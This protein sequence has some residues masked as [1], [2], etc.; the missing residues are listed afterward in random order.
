VQEKRRRCALILTAITLERNEVEKHLTQTREIINQN[1]PTV[2]R[3]EFE[4]AEVIWDVFVADTGAG[5]PEAAAATAWLGAKYSPELSI[6]V[7]VAGG[8]KDVSIGDVAVGDVVYYYEYAKV[9]EQI[10]C[11]PRLHYPSNLLLERA[12]RESTKRDWRKR[13]RLPGNVEAKVFIKPIAAGEK[14]VAETK[15]EPAQLIQNTYGDAIAVSME[16]FG[17]LEAWKN[18]RNVHAIAI[19]GISDM[20]EKKTAACDELNQP[21]AAAAAS[22]FAFELLSKYSDSTSPTE[23]A[24]L[25]QA[26]DHSVIA[27]SASE[28]DVIQNLIKLAGNA[29]SGLLNWPTTLVDGTWIQQDRYSAL[30]SK[31]M[32]ASPSCTIILG[33]PG[34]GKSALLSKLASALMADSVACLAIKADLLPA[35]I[36]SSTKLMQH[37]GLPIPVEELL[38]QI[39]KTRRVVLIIDQLDALADLSDLRTGRLNVL[40]HLMNEL[41][42][43]EGLHIVAS[44]RNFEAN[45]DTRINRIGGERIILEPPSWSQIEEYLRTKNVASD[46][47][48]EDLKDLLRYPEN[49][50]L[51]FKL[52]TYILTDGNQVTTQQKI[53]DA[54]WKKV[55]EKSDPGV[56]AVSEVAD[57]I[58]KREELWIPRALLDC[59]QTI[60]N[61][62]IED[63]ILILDNSEQLVSFRHQSLFEFTRAKVFLKNEGSL[64]NFVKERQNALFVRPLL[65]TTLHY[66]RGNDVLRFQQEF[67]ALWKDMS[68]RFHI[69]SLLIEF[70]GSQ[71]M[72]TEQEKAWLM[73][74]LLDPTLRSSVLTAVA[75]SIGWFETISESA[76]K[77]ILSKPVDECSEVIPLLTAALQFCQNQVLQL[78]KDYWL[79]F[80]ERDQLSFRVLQSLSLWD[81][82]S[83]E[84]AST[85][86]R[87]APL[88][89]M[90]VEYFI[91]KVS[92]SSPQGAVSL[93]LARLQYEFDNLP[94]DVEVGAPSSGDRPLDDFLHTTLQHLENPRRKQLIAILDSQDRFDSVE[95]AKKAPIHFVKLV[96]PWFGNALKE[97][98]YKEHEVVNKFLED[99][100]YISARTRKEKI[101]DYSIFAALSAAIHLFAAQSMEEFLQFVQAMKDTNLV[102]IQR[103]LVRGFVAIAERAP[104]EAIDFLLEDPRRLHIGTTWNE[105]ED[106]QTLIKALVPTSE[107]SDRLR[108]ENAILNYSPYHESIE[109]IEHRP[110][111]I[112]SARIRLLKSLEG[113]T[114]QTARSFIESKDYEVNDFDMTE[115]QVEWIGSPISAD[116]MEQADITALKST[117]DVLD[118]TTGDSHPSDFYLGG[119]IQ[120]SAE[121]RIMAKRQPEKAV[122]LIGQFSPSKNESAAAGA[123]EGLADSAIDRE[124]VFST[125]LECYRKGFRSQ[126]F[127][128]S[129][130]F[131]LGRIANRDT[132]FPPELVNVLHEFLRSGK[133]MTLEQAYAHPYSEEQSILFGY[134][135]RIV[136]NGT[137]PI[138]HA[139]AGGLLFSK[140]QNS[141]LWLQILEGHLD[142]EEN[143]AV[144][145]ELSMQYLVS[146][147]LV[148]RVRGEKFL[149]TLFEKHAALL[150]SEA[151]TK[152]IG[153]IH[154]HVSESLLRLW[155]KKIKDSKWKFGEQAY[156]E[157]LMLHSL[158]SSSSTWA[159]NDFEALILDQSLDGKDNTRILVGAA[160]VAA[161]AWSEPSIRERATGPLIDIIYTQCLPAFAA[162]CKQLGREDALHQDGSSKQ[163]LDA[164]NA[165]SRLLRTNA[166]LRLFEQL[167]DLVTMMPQTVLET[168]QTLLS[169]LKNDLLAYRIQTAW[170]SGIFVN[171]A[172]TLQRFNDYRSSGLDLFEELLKLGIPGATDAL[173]IIDRRDHASRFGKIG[174]YW[175]RKKRLKR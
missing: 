119:T 55:V 135:P 125:I 27:E 151:G 43:C 73:P 170:L 93:Y 63:G 41:K 26:P 168:C 154:L 124:I 31:V 70:L 24:T 59:N 172:L 126:E 65:W 49:L 97:V 28:Q 108:L 23:Y 7:G 53:L 110:K 75:G 51:F 99:G 50:L 20:L 129:T 83:I 141:Q 112:Y 159:K 147:L 174:R 78:I 1:G 16:D 2:T 152:L 116:E 82:D 121:L 19:R 166:D 146:T 30:L 137:F 158:T 17:F 15:S 136:P 62:L 157:L 3:G 94:E 14:V 68:L 69:R 21:M 45:H 40:L 71:T 74:A 10:R 149:E 85:I 114:S 96:M 132:E 81:K 153:K 5:N 155:L 123:I 57:H 44:C 101:E 54:W 138:F 35:E 36:D 115:P 104:K 9:D 160:Y 25:T 6:F 142:R 133:Y 38:E 13:I 162:I 61:K 171:I 64:F 22:A 107:E 131:V 145:E 127:V 105:Y 167:E 120:A 95:I 60:Q 117:F 91:G 11:R 39:A 66:L 109:L 77:T 165:N 18:Q 80:K 76:L 84:L 8:R 72:P 4:T 89:K 90:F 140:S 150:N 47:L 32:E 134:S 130:C 98:A 175:S 67:S 148:D 139:L 156:G 173:A 58:G 87:R 92:E 86:L 103:L 34:S 106:T 113:F 144:W 100:T 122:E 128:L 143:I 52:Q 29:S 88:D 164:V 42:E 48:S 79:P 102:S 169:E 12:K 111:T 37:L 161:G 33:Q 46:Q 163:F 118:D 56:A